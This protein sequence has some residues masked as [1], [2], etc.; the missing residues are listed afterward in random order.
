MTDDQQLQ[1]Q[2][3]YVSYCEVIKPLIAQIEACSEKLPL[4]LFNEIR[5]F[6]DHIARCYYNSPNKEY[7]DSQIDRA[8]RHLTRITLDCFK[9]L[10]VI[11]YQKIELFE[12]Q[13]RNVDLTVIDNGTFFPTYSRRKTQA[14]SLVEQAKLLE[15]KDIYEALFKYQDSFNLYTEI[16]DSSNDIS[17]KVKWARVRFRIRRWGTVIAWIASVVISAIISALFSCELISRFIS[18]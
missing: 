18:F 17:E 4:P 10:N 15:F 2:S 14:A 11:L 7:I 5:A 6:N 3:C 9:C 13:T 12:R 16:V 1:I 8:R